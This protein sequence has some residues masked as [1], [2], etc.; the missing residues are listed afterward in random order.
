MARPRINGRDCFLCRVMRG[1]AFG[2]L[3]AA[4]F[5]LPAKWLGVPDQQIAYYALFGALFVTA[6]AT[7]KRG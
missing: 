2:G 5:G 1:V 7:R 3:G 4:L 6:L